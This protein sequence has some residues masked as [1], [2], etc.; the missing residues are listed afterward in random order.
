MIA[1]PRFSTTVLSTLL[2]L[3][4]VFVLLS[5]PLAGATPSSSVGSSEASWAYGYLKTASFG[6]LRA[7]DGYL[8]EG[9]VTVG[10]EVIINETNTSS[11][12]FELAIHRT[13]GVAISIEFCKPNCLSSTYFANLTGRAYEDTFAWA[14]F[15]TSGTVEEN[16]QP[17]PAF[18]LLNSSSSVTSAL[19]ESTHSLLPRLVGGVAARSSSLSAE[20]SSTANVRFTPAL[21]LIPLNLTPGSE[22]SS[23][24]AYVAH[25]AAEYSYYYHFLGPAA[26]ITVNPP[27][28]SYNVSS[29]GN[30]SVVGSYLS[31]NA[32]SLGGVTFPAI[33][34]LISGPFSVREGIILIPN[35][36]D[37]F[38]SSTQP[39]TPEQNSSATVQ[40]VA[41][42]FKPYVRDHFGLEASSWSYAL[43]SADPADSSDAA[44][45][46]SPLTPAASTENPVATNTV[47]GQPEDPQEAAA[48]SQCLTSGLGCSTTG[49]P[50]SGKLLVGVVGAAIVAGVVALIVAVVIADRRRLPPPVYPNS[51]LYPRVTTGAPPASRSARPEPAPDTAPEVDPLDHLW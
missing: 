29:S 18:A 2:A 1:K 35:A 12:T 11:S 30:V 13:M 32:V 39:W 34:L 21:G 14:N 8:Y 19:T 49:A 44:T 48:G 15:T 50:S 4:M 26:N 23:S 46:V 20:I 5:S 16:A 28:G 41:V 24:S 45:A 3:L 33:T 17:A 10:Y 31:S 9:M 6:P 43:S 22:W 38:D 27:P 47:Q 25:G 40:A 37:L 36:T 42:D 7:S 51:N